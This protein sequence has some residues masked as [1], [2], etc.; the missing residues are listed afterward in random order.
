[1]LSSVP[2]QLRRF[3][4]ELHV[5]VLLHLQDESVGFLQ[6]P[7]APRRLCAAQPA[8]PDLIT[9]PLCHLV[10]AG[11]LEVCC[12]QPKEGAAHAQKRCKRG[13]ALLRAV[14]AERELIQEF[15]G[16]CIIPHL[17]LRTCDEQLGEMFDLMKHAQPEGK[18]IEKQLDL[19]FPIKAPGDVEVTPGVGPSLSFAR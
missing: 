6:L 10:A 8:L 1:M 7:R 18:L 16:N 19:I 12:T 4:E 5:L 9:Q 2:G 17:L 11:G 15:R 14:E 13:P 3:Q